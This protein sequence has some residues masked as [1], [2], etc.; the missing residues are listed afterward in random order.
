MRQYDFTKDPEKNGDDSIIISD[1]PKRKFDLWPR[2]ICLLLAFV[3]WIYFINLNDSDVTATVTVK[4]NIT[5]QD[6]LTNETDLL[7]YGIETQD[8]TITVKGT[9]RDIKKFSASD[10]RATVD[11]SSIDTSGKHTLEIVPTLPSGATI[12]V[13]TME[14]QNITLYTDISVTKPVPLNVVQGNIATLPAYQ[15]DIEQNVET[16][17]I[18]GPKT[19]IDTITSAQYRLEGEFYS[20]KSFSGFLLQ[21]CDANGDY[22]SY[23]SNSILYSTTDVVVNMNVT[24][25]QRIPVTVRVKGNGRDLAYTLSQTFVSVY[26]DPNAL[27]QVSE[28]MIVL[29]EAVAGRQVTVKLSSDELPENVE[30]ENEGEEISIS[31]ENKENLGE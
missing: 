1:R 22:V 2:L 27:A 7:I 13:V 20:S 14:P 17:D 19:V 23:D 28:Y 25:Q 6:S 4:L 16:I 18:T 31:F 8:V 21:F 5:G 10:Y 24:A 30:L 11:V 9:N 12:S 26:G 3:M 29:S 15:Y